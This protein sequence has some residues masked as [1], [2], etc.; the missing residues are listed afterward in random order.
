ML[1]FGEQLKN[2]EQE[3]DVIRIDQQK[4]HSNGIEKDRLIKLLQP[5]RIGLN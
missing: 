5:L 2:C 4:D 1:F 3:S